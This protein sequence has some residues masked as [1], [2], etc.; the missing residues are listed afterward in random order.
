[1]DYEHLSRKP[2][3][4][5]SFTGLGVD[6]FDILFGI[7]ESEYHAFEVKRLSKGKKRIRAEGAGRHF[8]S[9][10]QNRLLMLLVYYR[11]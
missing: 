5:R 10:L 1:M 6:E 9:K 11:L 8:K 2:S 4:F 3:I 7:I